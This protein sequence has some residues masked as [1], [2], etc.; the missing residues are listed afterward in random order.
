MNLAK[1]G[2]DNKLTQPN[3][4][5]LFVHNTIA[6]NIHMNNTE[7]DNKERAQRFCCRNTSVE[8]VLQKHTVKDSEH[9]LLCSF[10]Q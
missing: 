5:N 2:Y 7:Q 4:S 10:S 6:T 3:F 9:V 8:S 1:V